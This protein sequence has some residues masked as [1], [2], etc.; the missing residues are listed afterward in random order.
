ML[1]T[2]RQALVQEPELLPFGVGECVKDIY[3]TGYYKLPIPEKAVQSTLN[4]HMCRVGKKY[5]SDLVNL[6]ATAKDNFI[7]DSSR[8]FPLVSMEW[9]L[10]TLELWYQHGHALGWLGDRLEK[11]CF[12]VMKLNYG[13]DFTK[14]VAEIIKDSREVSNLNWNYTLYEF[15]D[16]YVCGVRS[17]IQYRDKT[18][19]SDLIPIKKHTNAFINELLNMFGFT[20][21]AKELLDLESFCSNAAKSY[22]EKEACSI[23]YLTMISFIGPS[24]KHNAKV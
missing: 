12:R 13:S 19:T 17:R 1:E 16:S 22:N 14:Q 24:N 6:A 2:F 5:N 7:F 10:A 23:I 21:G 11:K 15:I 20:W 18:Y 9:L 3:R 4:N 8:L